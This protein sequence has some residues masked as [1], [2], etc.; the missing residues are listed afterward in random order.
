MKTKENTRPI[1]TEIATDIAMT[2]AKS[3]KKA[4][5][6][7]PEKSIMPMPAP[8]RIKIRL[9]AAVPAPEKAKA[10]APAKALAHL[11]HRM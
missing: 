5:T 9:S 7:I 8:R 1:E 11:I 10:P 4:N 3:A 6:T 2:S